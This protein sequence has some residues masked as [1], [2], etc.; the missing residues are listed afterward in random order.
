MHLFMDFYLN[1]DEWICLLCS[2]KHHLYLVRCYIQCQKVIAFLVSL[3]ILSLFHAATNSSFIP[4]ENGT[5]FPLMP[6]QPS[7]HDNQNLKHKAWGEVWYVS[8]VL[9]H[10]LSSQP[11]MTLH[12]SFTHSH[13]H[14]VDTHIHTNTH[15]QIK[16]TDDRGLKGSDFALGFFSRTPQLM[17]Y[18]NLSLLTTLHVKAHTSY[19]SIPL[20]SLLWANISKKRTKQTNQNTCIFSALHVL[21]IWLCVSYI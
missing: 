14:S 13:T 4:A 9:I 12:S 7:L 20:L 6:L 11:S 5:V 1:K 18:Y 10:M 16:H 21:A 3:W 19:C 8:C 17:V 15:T 2:Q